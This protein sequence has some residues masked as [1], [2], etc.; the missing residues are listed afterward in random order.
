MEIVLLTSSQAGPLLSD[1]IGRDPG[2]PDGIA[3]LLRSE[4]SS[5]GRCPRHFAI[6]RVC[7]LVA[8]AVTLDP[9]LVDDVCDDLERQGDVVL[10][11]GA[12]LHP[13]P[14]RIVTLGDGV[15]RFV[16]TVPSRRLMEAVPGE[17]LQRGVRRDC[18]MK[19][20][21]ATAAATL[22]GIVLTPEAWAG[23]NNAP[24][25]DASFI[26][27]LDARLEAAP[28]PAG[29]LDH[30]EP[31]Q[32]S[33]CEVIAGGARWRG[34]AQDGVVAKL[35]RARHRWRRWIYA[36]TAGDAPSKQSFLSLHPDDGARAVYALGVAAGIFLRARVERSREHAVVTIPAWLPVAEYRYLST[37]AESTATDTPGVHWTV[38]LSRFDAVSA[39][40]ASRLGL[41][42]DDEATR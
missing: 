10:A 12:V 41:R 22:G 36:W 38:P 18:R 8:P 31:L 26:R 13:V 25:A 6:G 42:F 14:V 7:R 27:C 32:W 40:L 3:D 30:E 16:C 37:C 11:E 23:L 29:S 24:I 19:Q 20:P 4:V 39:T 17:W 15:C 33:T 1:L 2:S 5:R 35:W 34:K 28:G 21:I 9:A